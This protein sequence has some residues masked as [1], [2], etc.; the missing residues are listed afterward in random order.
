MA[1][2]LAKTEFMVDNSKLVNGDVNRRGSVHS[3]AMTTGRSW[4][5]WT[6]IEVFVTGYLETTGVHYYKI[7]LVIQISLFSWKSN[8]AHGLLL[9]T[10]KTVFIILVRFRLHTNICWI[11]HIYP[12]FRFDSIS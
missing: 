4:A 3:S 8:F 1:K 11:T 6:L 2:E 9:A 10:K 12:Q 7:W 5:L